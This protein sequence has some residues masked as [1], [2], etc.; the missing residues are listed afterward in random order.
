MRSDPSAPGEAPATGS[1]RLVVITGPSGAGKSTIVREVLQRTGADFAVSVTT[2][3]P[4]P[5]EV[6]GRDYRFVNR[7]TFQKMV[8]NHDLLEWAEVFGHLYG[9]PK[10]PVLDGLSRGRTVLLDI[11]IQG[12]LQ[13]HRQLPQATFILILPPDEAELRRRLERRRTE[14]PE[15]LRTRLRKAREEIRSARA[16]GIY[17]HTVVN[18]DLERAVR[19]VVRIL[20][21]ER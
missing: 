2:R 6:D 5:G 21:Q 19:Q 13:V 10:Q 20:R 4:R 11:D 3:P 8:E 1:G 17:T 15:Q 9:T 18:D 7:E 14:E 12:G 16:S